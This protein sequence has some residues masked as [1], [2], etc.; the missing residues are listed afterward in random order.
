MLNYHYDKEQGTY[1][2]YYGDTLLVELPY[3]DPM[4]DKQAEDLAQ[5]LFDTYMENE[6]EL[7]N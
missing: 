7:G 2:L 5:E 3:A 4:T 1:E 6:N